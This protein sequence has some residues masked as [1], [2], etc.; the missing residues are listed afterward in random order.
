M[1]SIL[2]CALVLGITLCG[3]AT[4]QAGAP[5]GQID[6]IAHRGASFVAPENTLAAFRR[7]HEMGADWFEL[8]CQLARDGEVIILHDSE[9]ERTTGAVGEASEYD[10]AELKKLDAGTW[11]SPTFAG[12]PIPTLAEALDFARGRIGVYIEIKNS[13]DD[14]ALMAQLLELASEQPVMTPALAARMGESIEAS[15]TRNLELTR[16]TIALVRERKMQREV[17]IQSFAPIICA[18]AR[19]EA[20]DIRVELLSG[21]E[22][23][24]SEEWEQTL[25]WAF[26]LDVQGINL[27]GEGALPGR[28]AVIRGSGKSVAVWTIDESEDMKRFARLGVDAIITDRPNICL[29]ALGRSR[30]K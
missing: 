20:P 14:G 11:K 2:Y 15:G 16:K 24:E 12:E 8:D 13:D 17:V 23:D 28:L 5:S 29:Q 27:R 26:L 9:L 3:C 30:P 22:A 21:V 4:F 7:A 1:R 25:R 18:I 10:L 19:I 6:V